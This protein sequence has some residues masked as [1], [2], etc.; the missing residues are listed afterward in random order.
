MDL[1]QTFPIYDAPDH[2]EPVLEDLM[3]SAPMQRLKRI[4]QL[5]TFHWF[6]PAW[7][8]KRFEH[9]VGVMLLLRKN[10]ASLEEQV[11]GLLHDVSHLAFSHVIDF[12]FPNHMEEYADRFSVDYIT[13][14]EV[15]EILRSYGFD[16][17]RIADPHQ[18]SLFEQ[19]RPHLCADRFDYSMRD[20]V[21]FGLLDVDRAKQF[22]SD[23]AVVDGQWA[24]TS[25]ALAADYARL[26]FQG[27]DHYYASPR[28]ICSYYLMAEAIRAALHHGSI[29]LEDLR[30][31]DVT[32]LEKMTACP[33]PSVRS[34]LSTL[35]QGFSV[36]IDEDNPQYVS[37]KKIRYVDP[38]VFMNGERKQVSSVDAELKCELDAFLADRAL[39]LK[40]RVVPL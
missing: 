12:V 13:K 22:H 4:H 28:G 1:V 14:G 16:P 24:F 20:A 18:F 29:T 31:D 15:E 34:L 35:Q 5:G 36:V 3:A 9:C 7:G 2:L 37:H 40:M 39:P 21:T 32:L 27:L 10:G 8:T 33:L 11:A 19:D 25:P 30:S 23:L 26:W 17:E 6:N 38:M